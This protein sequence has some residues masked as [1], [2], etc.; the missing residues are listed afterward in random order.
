MKILFIAT[1]L[2]PFIGSANIRGLNYINYLN[3]L[4]HEL[5]VITVDYPKDSIA[6]DKNSE[7]AFDKEV[8]I[9][10]V[11][12]GLLYNVSYTRKP[13]NDISN[14]SENSK[15]SFKRKIGS[16]VKKNILIPDSFVQ[17]IN[18]AYKKAVSLIESN[19]SY[20]C[21]FSM[22]ETP[23]SHVVAYKIKKKFPNLKWMGYWSDPWNG[24]SL[25]KGRSLI[26]VFLEEK[27]ERN[28]V[29]KVDK[30]F[31]TT[32]STRQMYINKYDINPNVTNVIYRGYDDTLYHD[33]EQEK[34]IPIELKND[35]INIVHT[36]TIYKELRDIGPLCTALEKLRIE[37]Y[38]LFKKI[39]V[40]FIGQFTDIQDENRMKNLENV[41]IKSLMP[42]KEALKYVV[43]A[44]V[45]LLYGNQNSTQVP[46]KVYEYLGSRAAV[47]TVL[48]D[49]KDELKDLMEQVNKGPIV[50]NNEEDIFDAIKSLE[51]RESSNQ[52]SWSQK[53]A[54]YKWI[55]VVK[56]LEKKILN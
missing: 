23:S 17:W 16:F 7:D 29:S 42:Y 20:D 31:F 28:I 26:K 6:Y 15:F 47:L 22:H 24:D 39:H 45:L 8:R 36:G 2:P 10:R 49:E 27:I 53:V 21:I 11:N 30:F 51:R 50:L 32:K 56:D 1:Q 40:L 55:N 3:R 18:P 46:G 19:G 54:E 33:I 35:K 4:G 41:T 5:D 25:R 34:K 38:N 14:R 43:Y 52:L 9:H 37:N 44:D 13:G 12:P 48:G